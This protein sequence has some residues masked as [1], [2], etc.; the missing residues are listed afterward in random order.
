MLKSIF[1]FLK[2]SLVVKG[3]DSKFI[4]QTVRV[5]DVIEFIFQDI[6]AIIDL[7]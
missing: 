7:N 1:K 4:N 2:L 3:S 5:A 6:H